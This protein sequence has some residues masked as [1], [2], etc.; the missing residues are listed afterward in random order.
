MPVCTSK[1][2]K[3]RYKEEEDAKEDQ[4]CSQC[5]DHV[6]EAQHS[7]PDQEE[8]EGRI[9][10]DRAQSIG[11]STGCAIGAP[12]VVEWYQSAG[13]GQPECTKTAEDDAWE[14]VADQP[15]LKISISTGWRGASCIPRRPIQG[16]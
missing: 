9:E 11:S 3:C 6:D 12:C 10:S 1:T 16:S 2:A 15:L 5:A 8:G 13:E 4:I 14:G 7:H